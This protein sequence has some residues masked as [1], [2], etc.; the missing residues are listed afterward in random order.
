MG[1][2][3]LIRYWVYK[4]IKICGG[5]V[6]FDSHILSGKSEDIRL[7]DFVFRTRHISQNREGAAIYP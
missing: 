6:L 4:A 7:A 5:H 2:I 1:F 3:A